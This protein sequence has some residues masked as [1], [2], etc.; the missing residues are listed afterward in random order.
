MGQFLGTHANRLDSK[1]RVS[2]PAAFRT[3]LARLDTTELVL[4]PSHKWPCIEAWPEPAFREFASRLDQF[5]A[6]SDEHDDL[7]IALFADAQAV[8]PDAEGRI[9][10][11]ERL[12]EYA[13]LEAG[14]PVAFVGFGKIFLIWEPGVAQQHLP[15]S[16]AR[17][18]ERGLTVPRSTRP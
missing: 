12:A 18:K 15:Q 9:V 3:T 11:N 5:D 1:G 4:R 17:A 10:L 8:S 14:K 16:I 6:F 7:A 2:V 13:G